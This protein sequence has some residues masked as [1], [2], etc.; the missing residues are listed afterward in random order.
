M[1]GK[2]AKP[3][4]ENSENAAPAATDLKAEDLAISNIADGTPEASEAKAL[5]LTGQL[6]QAEYLLEQLLEKNPANCDAWHAKGHAQRLQNKLEEAKE[7]YSNAIDVAYRYHSIIHFEHS[8]ACLQR[9]LL[10]YAM[11]EDEKAQAD[12]TQAIFQDHGNQAALY[13]QQH[14]WKRDM[15]L[16]EYSS[17]LMSCVACEQEIRRAPVKFD[18]LLPYQQAHD[19]AIYYWR[20]N[21][22][23]HAI[24]VMSEM[25]QQNKDFAMAWHHR[26]LMFLEMGDTRQ[27]LGDL[28]KS[29]EAG[30]KWHKNYHHDAALHHYHRGQ[31]Q[32]QMGD[33]DMAMMDITKAIEI[34]KN[35]AEAH[36]YLAHIHYNNGQIPTAIAD[37]DKALTVKDKPE[38]Q[39]LR[40]QWTAAMGG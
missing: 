9:A 6:T 33:G 24:G 17:N 7:S 36:V 13:L 39:E 20:H 5:V 31:L 15:Q 1:F 23:E 11:G 40:A 8:A 16:P 37:I 26:A 35:M 12:V 28:E 29:I 22:H 38:W 3:E 32:Q 19:K 10:L 18:D 4:A 2:S 34:D 25:L 27:A 30:E 14:G 21:Q